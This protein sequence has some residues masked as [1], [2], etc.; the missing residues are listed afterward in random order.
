MAKELGAG[1]AEEMERYRRSL[2]SRS[3]LPNPADPM[4]ID[5][6]L[7][8]PPE[9]T[10]FFDL[11]R[12]LNHDAARRRSAGSKSSEQPANRWRTAGGP[13]VPWN[14][15]AAVLGNAPRFQPSANGCARPG[16]RGTPAM[17]S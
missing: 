14:F 2:E 11:E 4:A 9:D 13:A 3:P 5:E 6:L 17:R 16:R 15:S 1:F 8:K 7:A 12:L 10:T